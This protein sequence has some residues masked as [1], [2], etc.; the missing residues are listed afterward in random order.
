MVSMRAIQS[1]ASW[2]SLSLALVAT[3]PVATLKPAIKPPLTVKSAIK[4]KFC[5]APLNELQAA[6]QSQASTATNHELCRTPLN[7]LKAASARGPFSIVY[8]H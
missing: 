8:C 2:V 6:D 4:P 7:E 3:N 1:H 5:R